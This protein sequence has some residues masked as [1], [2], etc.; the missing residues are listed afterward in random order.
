MRIF[1]ALPCGIGGVEDVKALIKGLPY[2]T[3]IRSK[4]AEKNF[5]RVLKA[6]NC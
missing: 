2:S 5:L 1:D 6:Y 4:I 3:E